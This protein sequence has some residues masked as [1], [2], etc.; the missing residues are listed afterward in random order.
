[1]EW[2]RILL[3]V[4]FLVVGGRIF[5]DY[6][7][8]KFAKG[9]FWAK[10]TAPVRLQLGAVPLRVVLWNAAAT[11]ISNGR[12]SGG[13]VAGRSC[14]RL[15][16][17]GTHGQGNGPPVLNGAAQRGFGGF[18]W[19][20]GAGCLWACGNVMHHKGT[21]Q[22]EHGIR[23]Y[24]ENHYRGGIIQEW[25]RAKRTA[26]QESIRVPPFRF[27]F[28][29][30]SLAGLLTLMFGIGAVPGAFFA[31]CHPACATCLGGNGPSFPFR[32]SLAALPWLFWRCYL[33][34]NG[35]PIQLYNFRRG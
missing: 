13:F 29:L 11:L 33:G 34:T 16:R 9:E 21:R 23:R 24:Y 22:P 6:R 30:Q 35:G 27:W 2:A 4:R 1:M 15:G 10:R 20:V 14:A 17:P 3:E 5:L 19:A 7:W 8:R 18:A 32:C 25:R 31:C 12:A 26:P 28:T